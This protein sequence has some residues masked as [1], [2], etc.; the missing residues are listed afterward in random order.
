M[1]ATA[2]DRQTGELAHLT[3]LLLAERA[4]AAALRAELHRERLARMDL[5]AELDAA[6][7]A[8]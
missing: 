6:R 8:G 3:R 2:V 4:E 5:L 7:A 1:D